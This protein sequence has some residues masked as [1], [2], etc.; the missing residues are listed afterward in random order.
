MNFGVQNLNLN[1]S[2]NKNLESLSADPVIFDLKAQFAYSY[3][4]I[5]K[6][7]KILSKINQETQIFH[8]MFLN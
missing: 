5:T 1:Y 8:S 3:S 2:G 6:H 4:N 7:S